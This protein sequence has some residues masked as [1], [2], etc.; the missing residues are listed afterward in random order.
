M[1]FLKFLIAIVLA[2]TPLPA[3]DNEGWFPVEKVKEARGEGEETDPSIWALFSKNLGLERF[4]IKFPVE[5]TYRYDEAGILEIRSEREGELYILRVEEKGEAQKDRF[6]QLEGKWIREHFVQT[7]H[8]FFHFK[9]VS[10]QPDSLAYREFISSF[11]IEE[12]G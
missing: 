12:I 2:S 6:Y 11:L 9:F 10:D 3:E 1:G 7:P 5:P 4:L 8:H